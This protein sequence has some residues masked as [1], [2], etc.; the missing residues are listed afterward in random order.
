MSEG[1]D[2]DDGQ[3]SD[4]PDERDPGDP[5]PP[6]DPFR[7]DVAGIDPLRYGM[8]G[9]AT[10][11]AMAGAWFLFSFVMAGLADPLVVTDG[12]FGLSTREPDDVFLAISN[13][14]ALLFHVGPLLGVLLG[15]VVGRSVDTRTPAAVA[16]AGAVT[17]G[18]AAT[19]FLLAILYTLTYPDSGTVNMVDVLEPAF[20]STLGIAVACIGSAG[21]IGVFESMADA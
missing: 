3:S 12:P 4:D 17:V 14:Y 19:L 18:V 9:A 20:A 11:G 16:G 21:A 7:D 1:R 15:L 2:A 13:A 6:P 5:T 8:L 10:A